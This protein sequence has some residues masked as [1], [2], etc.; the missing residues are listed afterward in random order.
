MKLIETFYTALHKRMDAM[1]KQLKQYFLPNVSKERPHLL[2]YDG[3]ATHVVFEL[4]DVAVANQ[5][6]IIK[7]SPHSAY[8]L[9]A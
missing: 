7:L 3:R 9:Q 1:N 6:T 5:I 8:Y 4:I 2:M